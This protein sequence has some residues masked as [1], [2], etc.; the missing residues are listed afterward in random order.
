LIVTGPLAAVSV[1][2]NSDPAAAAGELTAG[3]D[4]LPDDAPL[5]AVLPDDVLALAQPARAAAAAMAITAA[6]FG[7]SGI[8]W[9]PP[10]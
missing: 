3:L 7:V 8:N 1:T 4:A 5:D 9:L 2:G 6:S 10:E